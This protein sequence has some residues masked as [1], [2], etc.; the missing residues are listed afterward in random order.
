MYL[1]FGGL[2]ILTITGCSAS[3][4]AEQFEPNSEPVVWRLDNLDRI[5]GHPVTIEGEPK[6]ID[7]PNGKA[8]EFDGV[9]DAI[10]LNVHPLQ[11]MA[12]FTGES[13][14]S[15]SIQSGIA[16]FCQFWQ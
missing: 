7:T 2:T 3:D 1:L 12:A 10:F 9:D 11:G 6:V 8:I 15:T 14:R 5:G 13:G 16:W 4:Q